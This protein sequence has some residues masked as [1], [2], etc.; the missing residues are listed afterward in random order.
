MRKTPSFLASDSLCPDLNMTAGL[1]YLGAG[2]EHQTDDFQFEAKQM[3][4]VVPT[5]ARY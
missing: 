3:L 2:R 5:R 4:L 1:Y